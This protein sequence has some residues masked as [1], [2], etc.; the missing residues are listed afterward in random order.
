MHPS[1][2][3][4]EEILAVKGMMKL[5]PRVPTAFSNVAGPD[6]K[7]EVLHS[8]VAGPFVLGAESVG[9]AVAGEEAGEW[10]SVRAFDVFFEGGGGGERLG[11]VGARFG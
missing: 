2:V 4:R 9:A 1:D 11:A 10:T 7:V 5:G 6:L 8:D 3:L